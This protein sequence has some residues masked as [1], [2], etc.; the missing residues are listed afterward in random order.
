MAAGNIGR[1]SGIAAAQRDGQR[2]P[3]PP[4]KPRHQRLAG[5]QAI[6]RECQPA[7]PVVAVR[8]H[9][10]LMQHQLRPMPGKQCA[11]RRFQRGEIIGIAGAIGQSDIVGRARLS[12]R[13]IL[14]GMDGKRDDVT[15]P[16]HDTSRAIALVHVA[17]DNQDA[18]RGAFGHQPVGGDGEIIGDAIAGAA[19]GTG[20]MAATGAVCSPAVGEG[21]ERCSVGAADHQPRAAGYGG[22]NGQADAAFDFGRHAG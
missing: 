18:A 22:G 12:H 7:K 21:V 3:G 19:V 6:I 1:I 2:C 17:I 4:R 13:K 11:E 10:G 20:M 14:F 8:V 16:G 9:A 15:A 5:G